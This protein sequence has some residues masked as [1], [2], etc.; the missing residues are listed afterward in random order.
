MGIKRKVVKRRA[1]KTK[2]AA[3]AQPLVE[4]VAVEPGAE[5]QAALTDKQQRFIDAYLMCWNA[6]EAARRAGYSKQTAYAIGWENLRKPEIRSAIDERLKEF[7]LSADEV[8]AMLSEQARNVAAQYIITDKSGRP[9]VDVAAM[10]RDGKQHLI[11]GISYKQNGVEVE[12]Y[13]AHAAKF[14]IGKHHRLFVDR[15][16]HEGPNGGPIQVEDI[17]VT[18]EKRWQEFAPTLAAAMTD[19]NEQVN[20]STEGAGNG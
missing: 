5:T 20:D 4:T 10:I 18:R 17:N 6:T 1:A 2:R 7:H 19:E 14:L 13:D 3:V 9:K 12:F 16:E 15:V 8:L 11:K